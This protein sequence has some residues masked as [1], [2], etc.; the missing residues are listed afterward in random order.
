[1]P[2]KKL[3]HRLAAFVAA[4]LLATLLPAIGSATPAGA[5]EL[6]PDLVFT[7][8]SPARL[9]DTRTAAGGQAPITSTT[10][11]QLR[12]TGMGGLPDSGVRAIAANLTAVQPASGG[13]LTAWA[14][15]ARPSTSNVNYK[16]GAITASL[17]IVEVGY[18][19][20]GHGYI[21]IHSSA[22]SHV[23][24]DVAG[25]FPEGSDYVPVAPQR[26]LDTRPTMVSGSTPVPVAGAHGV[27]ASGVRA[28]AVTLTVHQPTAPGY[29]TAFQFGTTRPAASTL[30]Y[31]ANETV[32]NFAIVPVDPATGQI[33]VFLSG[34][35]S[36]VLVDVVG[37]F[38]D[39]ADRYHPV[40]DDQRFLDTRRAVD[41]GVKITGDAGQKVVQVAGHAGIPTAGVAA[42]VV[43]VTVVAPEQAGFVTLYPDGIDRPNVSTLNLTAGSAPLANAAIVAVGENGAIR[44]HAAGLTHVVVDVVGWIPVAQDGPPEPADLSINGGAA[45]TNDRVVQL[46]FPRAGTE[47]RIANGTDPGGAPWQPAVG[48]IEWTLP[49]GDGPKTVSAQFRTG[50]G[51]PTSRPLARQI[52]L[53]TVPPAITQTAATANQT[54]DLTGGAPFAIGGAV[55][56]DQPGDVTVQVT[57]DGHPSLEPGDATIA[58]SE[59]AKPIDSPASGP[60]TFVATATDAAGNTSSTSVTLNLLVPAEDATLVRSTVVQLD[61]ALLAA[62]V[63][64]GLP[65]GDRLVFSGDRRADLAGYHVIALQD[66]KS[67]EWEPFARR[68]LEVTYDSAED[69]TEVSTAEATLSDLYAR[70]DFDTDAGD[71]NPDVGALRAAV[72]N[73][74][75]DSYTVG[76]TFVG[77]LPLVNVSG[78]IEVPKAGAEI[79]AKFDGEL[80][81]FVDA[82]AK[83]SGGGVDEFRVVVGLLLC[84]EV[85][86]KAGGTAK[87][88]PD[89]PQWEGNGRPYREV[90][91]EWKGADKPLETAL[92]DI[93]GGLRIPLPAGFGLS[94]RVD[95]RASLHAQANFDLSMASQVSIGGIFGVDKDADGFVVRDGVFDHRDTSVQAKGSAEIG[96]KLSAD[97]G[98]TVDG[99]KL[100]G[101]VANK[102]ISVS[103]GPVASLGIAWT[104]NRVSSAGSLLSVELKLCLVTKVSSGFELEV[105]LG[106]TWGPSWLRTGGTVFKVTFFDKTFDGPCLVDEKWPRADDPGAP[107]ITQQSLRDATLAAPYVATITSTGTDR[108][109][110]VVSGM[111]PDGLSLNA[112]TG[113]I[114]GVPERVASSSFTV[115][116][117]DMLQRSAERQLSITVTADQPPKLVSGSGFDCLLAGGEVSC[118]GLQTDSNGEPTT[119][120]V[121]VPGA[122]G[123]R[124]IAAAG[125]I[126]VVID[127]GTVKCW[128]GWGSNV[129]GQS[130][131]P[132]MHSLPIEVPSTVQGVTGARSVAVGATTSCAV[133][134]GGEVYCWGSPLDPNEATD[135]HTRYVPRPV[136]GLS[137][138]RSLSV[139]G[140]HACAIVAGG[141][142]KCWGMS[143]ALLGPNGPE[144]EGDDRNYYSPVDVPGVEDAREIAVHHDV[145]CAREASGTVKCW[146]YNWSRGLGVQLPAG[147][148]MSAEPVAVHG[149]NNA[150]ALSASGI[151]THHCAVD[152]GIV[153]CWGNSANG[154]T[155]A[156]SWHPTPNPVV[157][158]ATVSAGPLHTCAGLGPDML[159]WGTSY[160]RTGSTPIPAP[161][162]GS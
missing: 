99:A 18:E 156:D 83:I 81:G 128:G 32:A 145:S 34:G 123:A 74:D 30:N 92:E 13:F 93:V 59:W 54:V 44:V 57:V 56:D 70:L 120:A 55:S 118:R 66:G 111:L 61:G 75:C 162:P 86:L 9:L 73:K 2:R 33:S 94:P 20:D 24:V 16:A 90:L 53:D 23:L 87:F 28:V 26:F 19:S 17:A 27:P 3:P 142:V 101:A 133:V 134:T 52:V 89:D 160:H 63:D 106:P 88:N 119:T 110:E 48:P 22:S 126:C 100:V 102:I 97:F 39:E 11:R 131:Q 152:G 130:G 108:T 29:A 65:T 60:H 46:T 84:G 159:C 122:A 157:Y 105:F 77:A 1:M 12:V 155:G 153:K 124:D 68:A 58:G 76:R 64:D 85:E 151:G 25:W 109:W 116:T 127:D 51:R 107:V 137:G 136:P 139:G 112:A 104:N 149:V 41:G 21:R 144:L 147:E 78:S 161:W 72:A 43:N 113:V 91:D 40:L 69:V 49:A 14:Q 67:E 35:S 138:V 7:P 129:F 4:A 95:L 80:V 114:S 135:P 37:W 132:G 146:G 150:T 62:L 103:T 98:A 10:P 45:A 47:I 5:E 15:G 117:T 50:L 115:R 38:S 140:S 82:K 148:S 79:S 121:V 158:A 6:V 36:H 31:A 154:A 96:V 71:D 125:H 42:V 8:V 141:A 143:G